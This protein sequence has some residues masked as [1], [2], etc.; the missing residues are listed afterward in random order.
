MLDTVKLGETP[1]EGFPSF[2]LMPEIHPFLRFRTLRE[3]RHL[4][5]PT[6]GFAP[7][8]HFLFF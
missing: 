8:P 5:M 3:F 2:W 1:G 7:G 4:R 6:K